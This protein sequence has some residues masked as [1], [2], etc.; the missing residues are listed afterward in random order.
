MTP[1][2]LSA[3][4][5]AALLLCGCRDVYL[6]TNCKDYG[7]LDDFAMS[8][9]PFVDQWDSSDEDLDRKQIEVNEQRKWANNLSDR[10]QREAYL[11][12]LDLDDWAISRGREN[13]KETRKIKEYQE[14]H[15]IPVFEE[16]QR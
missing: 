1:G 8:H 13:N 3:L 11:K 14:N 16:H 12:W 7:A 5:C 9:T 10:C 15:K 2:S 6:A 4:L